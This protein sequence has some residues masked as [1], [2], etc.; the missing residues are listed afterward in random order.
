[1]EK[2]NIKIQQIYFIIT[3]INMIS[4]VN[5]LGS[6]IEDE[7]IVIEFIDIIFQEKNLF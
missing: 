1:M 6:K 5:L 7:H 3:D 4:F 2:Y